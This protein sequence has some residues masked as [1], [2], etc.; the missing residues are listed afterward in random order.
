MKEITILGVMSPADLRIES[1]FKDKGRAGGTKRIIDKLRVFENRDDD[2]SL[3]RSA[4]K[5]YDEYKSMKIILFNE[6]FSSKEYVLFEATIDE[7]ALNALDKEDDGLKKILA[8]F[9][10]ASNNKLSFARTPNARQIC[11]LIEETLVIR[12]SREYRRWGSYYGDKYG[13]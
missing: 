10:D 2:E 12:F 8:L 5:E 1:A 6:H 9:N 13:L 4:F 11:N 7:D 3:Y